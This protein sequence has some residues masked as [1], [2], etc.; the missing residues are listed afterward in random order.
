MKYGACPNELVTTLVVVGPQVNV[1]ELAAM[2][3]GVTWLQRGPNCYDFEAYK[4]GLC[5]M[6]G[7][8][9]GFLQHI[10]TVMV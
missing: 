7:A 1:T 2:A 6:L 9:I 5:Q 3:P 8:R 10:P 4:V